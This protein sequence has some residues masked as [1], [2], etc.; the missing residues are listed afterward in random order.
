VS[1][2]KDISA[3]EIDHYHV[4]IIYIVFVYKNYDG[5]CSQTLTEWNNISDLTPFLQEIKGVLIMGGSGVGQ[6]EVIITCYSVTKVRHYLT[7]SS[8][9]QR[10]FLC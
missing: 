7:I 3:K 9:M 5:K 4:S 8:A 6:A 2:R 10:E 1:V